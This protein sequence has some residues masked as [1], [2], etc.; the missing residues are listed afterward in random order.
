MVVALIFI[1]GF[2]GV[3]GEVGKL[4]EENGKLLHEKS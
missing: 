3:A 2:I 1:L 4:K